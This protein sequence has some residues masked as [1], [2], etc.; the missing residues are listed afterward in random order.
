[1]NKKFTLKFILLFL[2]IISSNQLNTKFESIKKIP[3]NL[4]K[5]IINNF[6]LI[7]NEGFPKFYFNNEMVF[8]FS[9]IIVATI[10]SII[11]V[12]RINVLEINKMKNFYNNIRALNEVYGIE[13]VIRYLK[14]FHISKWIGD[15]N[16]SLITY[17]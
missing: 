1:M 12:C 6:N 14:E 10:I 5:S 16:Y 7:K 4:S 13:A 3:S 15:H 2:V 17:D 9:I 11:A 8:L